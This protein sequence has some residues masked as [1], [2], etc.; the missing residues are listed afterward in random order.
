MVTGNGKVKGTTLCSLW[1]V[2]KM[3]SLGIPMSGV[4]ESI[5]SRSP[6]NEH[7]DHMNKI[8]EKQC[9]FGAAELMCMTLLV[10][11]CASASRDEHR[12]Q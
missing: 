7:I 11:I 5:R 3:G 1:L 6:R 10:D 8:Y 12:I 4:L 2:R 9:P